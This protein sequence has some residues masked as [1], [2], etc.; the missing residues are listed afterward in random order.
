[1]MLSTQHA[2]STS[3]QYYNNSIECPFLCR[4]RFNLY[5]SSVA[6]TVFRDKS[7]ELHS[8]TL[9]RRLKNVAHNAEIARLVLDT[10]LLMFTGMYAV[11]PLNIET[12]AFFRRPGC[13]YP[14]TIQ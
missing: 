11:L 14:K 2:L 8:G 10:T 7:A 1:M 6:E 3:V 4:I 5:T 9:C 12:L 13:R